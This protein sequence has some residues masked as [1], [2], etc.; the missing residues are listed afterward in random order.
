MNNKQLYENAL[1][2]IRKLFAD[3]SVDKDTA[4][5]NLEGLKDEIEILIESLG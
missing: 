1:E 4:I 5:E 3:T 2:A